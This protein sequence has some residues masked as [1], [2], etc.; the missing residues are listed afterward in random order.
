MP[1]VVDCLSGET[2]FRDDSTAI[3][4]KECERLG[5][6]SKNY[7]VFSDGIGLTENTSKSTIV[8]VDKKP[9]IG[10]LFW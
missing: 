3:C 9:A 10:E 1:R 4:E 2:V 6:K 8:N 5:G 7:F